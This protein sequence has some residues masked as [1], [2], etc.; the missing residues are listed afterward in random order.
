[1][2]RRL[3]SN[4]GSPVTSAASVSGLSVR[5]ALSGRVSV[6]SRSWSLRFSLRAGETSAWKTAQPMVATVAATRMGSSVSIR[7]HLDHPPL[8]QVLR[9]ADAAVVDLV[10]ASR[11]DAGGRE[12]PDRVP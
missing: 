7:L 4:S 10:G 6:L 11:T 9:Q 3:A 12:T 5:T 8:E 1:M 2:N